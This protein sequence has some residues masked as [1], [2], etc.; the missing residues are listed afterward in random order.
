MYERDASHPEGQLAFITRMAPSDEEEW[1]WDH[2][3]ANV[4]PDGRFLVFTS[5]RA[6]TRG[7]DP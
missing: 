7:C 3:A 6:L 2:L 5:H 1:K 4:T